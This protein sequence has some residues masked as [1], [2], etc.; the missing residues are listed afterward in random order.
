MSR[1]QKLLFILYKR[2]LKYTGNAE[3]I[4]ATV[5]CEAVESAINPAPED[6]ENPFVLAAGQLCQDI[7]RYEGYYPL[8]EIP[9]TRDIPLG[10]IWE[11]T[12]LVKRA[13]AFYETT[14]QQ[15]KVGKILRMLLYNLL[16]DENRQ[17][18][19]D[20]KLFRVADE[21]VLFFATLESLHDNIPQAIEA[22]VAVLGQ[23]AGTQA[24]RAGDA[25]TS[26]ELDVTGACPRISERNALS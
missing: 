24:Q 9:F 12:A 25:Q 17:P 2:L 18:W 20:E 22:A 15:E 6:M 11:L 8:P 10:E 13:H 16:L 21:D 5:C 7:L 26:Q 14:Q 3:E 19:L 4:S 1:D 23:A